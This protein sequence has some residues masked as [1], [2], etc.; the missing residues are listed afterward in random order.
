MAKYVIN[1]SIKQGKVNI[2]EVIERFREI[3]P[4]T[5]K[6]DEEVICQRVEQIVNEFNRIK[7]RAFLLT[8][9]SSLLCAILG[10]TFLSGVESII[11]GIAFIL[12]AIGV[13]SGIKLLEFFGNIDKNGNMK[14]TF[15]YPFF[16]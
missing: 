3:I 1:F 13:I 6:H 15:S 16:T 2:E 8:A 12:S 14:M 5:T 11:I 9:L 4:E 7:K 10:I